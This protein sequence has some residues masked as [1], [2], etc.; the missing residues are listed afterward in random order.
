MKYW[1]G[2]IIGATIGFYSGSFLGLVLG[3]LLGN[4]FDQTTRRRISGP[5]R[6]ASLGMLQTVFF[7]ATFKVMGRMAKSDGR[8]TEHEIN[9]ARKIMARMALKESQRLEAMRLFNEGKSPET[10]IEPLLQDLAEVIGRQSG[11]S[12]MFLEIQ[13]MAA[14]ADGQL[15]SVERQLLAKISRY[16]SISP[17]QFEIIHQRV[18]IQVRYSSQ[19]GQGETKRQQASSALVDAYKV[20]GV[21]ASASEAE[22]KK[23]YRRL[24]SQHH[25]DKLL[26]KGLP[27]SMMEMAKQR[28]Q[29]I[30]QAYEQIKSAR[31]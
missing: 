10:Q 28:T 20:L 7:Q 30:Q 12:Q 25:P 17:I 4:A 31:R 6:P 23:A 11:L 1:A 21:E 14:Y 2:K 16:L 22:V 15:N 3:L 24:M 26:A 9:M 5:E 19:Q 13:L 27:E 29:Q 18:R 8:V